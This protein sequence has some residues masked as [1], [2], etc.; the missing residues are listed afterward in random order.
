MQRKGGG[1]ERVTVAEKSEEKRTLGFRKKRNKKRNAAHPS[2]K[3]KGG[4]ERS[5]P[6]IPG[7]KRGEQWTFG[8]QR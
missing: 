6:L 2:Q 4:E 5:L 8:G 7:K 1:G 3:N